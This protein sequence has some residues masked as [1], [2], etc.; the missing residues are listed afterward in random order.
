[1][2]VAKKQNRKVHRLIMKEERPNHSP[3]SFDLPPANTERWVKSRKLAVIQAIRNGILSE[4]EACE[5]YNLSAEELTS[6]NSLLK[7]H[8]PDALRTTHLKRYRKAELRDQN[9]PAA[10]DDDTARRNL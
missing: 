9:F 4:E 7:R 2:I 3:Q 1:M 5:R 10:R 8:G 6:W